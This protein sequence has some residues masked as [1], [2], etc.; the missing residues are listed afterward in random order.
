MQVGFITDWLKIVEKCIYITKIKGFFL[1]KISFF[2]NYTILLNSFRNLLIIL[3]SNL[4][5]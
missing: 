3:F 1:E 4:E 5:I 2:Q